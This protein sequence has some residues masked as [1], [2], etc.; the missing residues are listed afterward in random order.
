MKQE[1]L[2]AGI[3]TGNSLDAVDVVLTKF[4][5]KAISDICG[6]TEIIP[7]F[8]AE[9]FRLVKSALANNGGDIGAFYAENKDFFEELHQSYINL[10]ARTVA[11]MLAQNG[12]CPDGVDAVGFHGQTCYHFPPS[13]AG[14]GCE[15]NTLQ[16]GSGQMLSNLLNIPVVYDFRSD[17][18]MS[19]GEGAPLAPVHNLHLAED[20]RSK[21]IFPAVFCNGGNTGNLAIVYGDGV[22]GW[23]CGPF[24]HFADTLVRVEKNE[25]C[26][27]DG[28]YGRKGKVNY[29][30][31]E[32]LFN[33]SV[34]TNSGE[35]FILKNPPKSSDPAWYKMTA[36]LS[37]KN[38]PFED[39]L[40]TVEFFSAY[41]MAYNL[42]YA[43]VKTPDYFLIFGGGWNNPLIRSDFEALLRGTADV[44]PQHKKI[45]A[46]IANDK[47]SV[48]WSDKFG[49]AGKYMEARIFA[50]M[51]K[52]RLTNEPFSTPLTT[53]CKTPTVGGIVAY[54]DGGDKRLWSRAAKGWSHK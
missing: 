6:H 24:N 20:L 4:K 28:K 1:Y 9:G 30:L 26:D 14:E 43:P 16:I 42:I 23:D 13:V 25:N 40:R 12:I 44:L 52:C 17:D 53:G 41:I 51:A 37:E 15:P 10:V 49:Y 29:V 7:D 27:Y 22:M 48:E 39:R 54:P 36:S 33:Q 2:C 31:L 5:G 45:F 3:M 50:D 38:L 19:G 18:I 47:V 32:E 8:V 35:N 11:K 46:V 21:G 34:Q